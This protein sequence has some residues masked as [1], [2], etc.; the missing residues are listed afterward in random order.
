MLRSNRC[1]HG[2]GHGQHNEDCGNGSVSR[3]SIGESVPHFERFF[4]CLFIHSLFHIGRLIDVDGSSA[5]TVHEV[6]KLAAVLRLPLELLVVLEELEKGAS[7]LVF[8]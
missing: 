3:A 4:N 7:L 5:A 6:F 1:E 2:L 8:R